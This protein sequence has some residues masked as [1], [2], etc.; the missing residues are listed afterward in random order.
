[1]KSMELRSMSG[2]ELEEHVRELH[3]ELFNLRFRSATQQLDNS[4]RMRIAR[5]DLAR[6]LTIRRERELGIET[7][8]AGI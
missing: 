3:R 4:L 2:E 7:A 8:G 5:R 6:A 1:M